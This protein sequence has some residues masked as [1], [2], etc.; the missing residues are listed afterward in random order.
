MRRN[1]INFAVDLIT[2]LVLVA[3]ALT[4]LVMRYALPPGTGG[5]HGEG[6]LILWGLT[7]H[8]WGSVHFWLAVSVGVLILLHLWLHWTWV[9]T[10]LARLLTRRA[11]V[12]RR[13]RHLAGAATLI[14]VIGGNV[15]FAWLAQ[16]QVRDLPPA[17]DA[18]SSP[19]DG[20]HSVSN[21]E[22]EHDDGLPPQLGSRTL[23]E[24]QQLTGVAPV[25]L[26]A[27]LGLPPDTPAE[28][29]V[30]QLRQQHN[31]SMEQIR[32]AILKL[33]NGER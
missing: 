18:T 10:M 14:L 8:Q 1:W 23:S 33:R 6:G 21:R 2:A 16:S 27:A 25:D 30:G 11:E 32:A 13:V 22:G 7:R 31:L 12:T 24:I 17:S 15:A 3:L 4:G 29:R 5:R 19:R 20:Q 26:L 28:T 9:T